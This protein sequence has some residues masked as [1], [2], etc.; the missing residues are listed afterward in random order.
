MRGSG[1]RWVESL[2]NRELVEGI[3]WKSVW[4]WLTHRDTQTGRHA[5][6]HTQTIVKEKGV[7]NYL[8]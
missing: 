3:D 4:D 1:G 6:A 7:S 5:Q 8:F 2:V